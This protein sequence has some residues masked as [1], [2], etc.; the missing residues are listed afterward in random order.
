MRVLSSTLPTPR[1][2][3]TVVEDV[4]EKLPE[5]VRM[6]SRIK[7]VSLFT[8]NGRAIFLGLL[9]GALL[10]CTFGIV[11]ARH[12][13]ARRHAE[14]E[15]KLLAASR[16]S[17]SQSDPILVQLSADLIHVTAISLGQPRLAIINGKHLSEG[18]QITVQAPSAQMAVTLRVLKIADGRVELTD[19]T[20]VITARVEFPIPSRPKS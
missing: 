3:S 12:Q 1:L 6:R 17:V 19:G 2:L 4:R 15:R 14:N 13:A 16:N 9:V 7:H 5:R 18:D 20:Q 11:Y 10:I 8:G